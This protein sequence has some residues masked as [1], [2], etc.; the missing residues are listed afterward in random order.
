[1]EEEQVQV[2]YFVRSHCWN[3]LLFLLASMKTN[4]FPC[5]LSLGQGPPRQSLIPY[6]Q[7]WAEHLF[8]GIAA[9]P[10]DMTTRPD[11][12]TGERKGG[13][14]RG[15]TVKD[16]VSDGGT[17]KSDHDDDSNRNNNN[18][19]NNNEAFTAANG[20]QQEP[21][22]PRL[23]AQ[24]LQRTIMVQIDGGYQNEF[25]FAQRFPTTAEV[26]KALVP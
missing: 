11:H 6:F 12:I 22:L 3:V 24:K 26:W 14:E 23:T 5:I 18:S 15:S 16:H 4:I 7:T 2:I 25:L 20:D 9:V 8:L 13:G 17:D 19:N 10:V 1:M 21:P